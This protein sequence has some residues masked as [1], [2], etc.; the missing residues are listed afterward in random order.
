M[1]P[2]QRYA[3]LSKWLR[4]GQS[5]KDRMAYEML[6]LV[7]RRKTWPIPQKDFDAAVDRAIAKLGADKEEA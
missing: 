2:E 1:S 6:G 7:E 3:A 5:V 4:G